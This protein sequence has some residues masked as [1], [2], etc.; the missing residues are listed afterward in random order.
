[1]KWIAM[2]GMMLLLMAV[3][4]AVGQ[5]ST[6]KPALELKQWD[7]WIGDW[8]LTGTA[9]DSAT[10]PEY[11]VDWHMHGHWILDGFFAEIDYTMKSNGHEEHQLEILSYDPVKKIHSITGFASDGTTW[12]L[13][14]TFDHDTSI[15]NITVTAPDGGITTCRN[16]FHFTPDRMA[17]SGQQ[18]CEQ[19]GVRW[20][21]FKVKGTKS[22][23]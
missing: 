10:G 5:S 17:A 7:V 1:M 14:A 6:P 22:R 11:K 16:T 23:K 20:T 9:K 3:V 4:A 19:S 13:T 12:V 8:T 21:A 15:E 2:V 18:E